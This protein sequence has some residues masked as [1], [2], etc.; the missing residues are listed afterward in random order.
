MAGGSS[1]ESESSAEADPGGGWAS[2]LPLL[3]AF[4]SEAGM[5]SVSCGVG[6]GGVTGLH[7]GE[8]GGC[9]QSGGLPGR[10]P[11]PEEDR[12]GLGEAE[13]GRSLGLWTPGTPRPQYTSLPQ[14]REKQLDTSYFLLLPWLKRDR[15]PQPGAPGTQH[16]LRGPSILR[17]AQAALRNPI[18]PSEG[19]APATAAVRVCPG[20]PTPCCGLPVSPSGLLFRWW[21][22]WWC[23]RGQRL[24]R[25]GS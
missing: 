23:G 17:G 24:G 19:L 12:F 4:V 9:D 5:F 21:W 7:L 18:V 1:S 11:R 8:D 13:P 3:L 16:R 2:A 22:Q 14:T 20:R 6:T 15:L 10:S 25:G